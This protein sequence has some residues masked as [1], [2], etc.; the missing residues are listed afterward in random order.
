MDRRFAPVRMLGAQMR[1]R[2]TQVAMA[3]LTFYSLPSAMLHAGTCE[4]PSSRMI[5]SGEGSSLAVSGGLLAA[6]F[7]DSIVLFDVSDSEHAK[8]LGDLE[9]VT[10][11]PDFAVSM[12]LEAP[13]LAAITNLGL[14][15]IDISCPASPKIEGFIDD[16][17]PEN[18]FPE[19]VILRNALAFVFAWSANGL[20]KEGI[21][22]YDV[23]QPAMPSRI[24]FV[25]LDGVRA[26]AASGRF[27][28]A[29]R[30]DKLFVIDATNAAHPEVV[31]E[32]AFASQDNSSKIVHDTKWLYVGASDITATPIVRIYSLASL[33]DLDSV[34]EISIPEA[35]SVVVLDKVHDFLFLSSPE[36]GVVAYDVADPQHAFPVGHSLQGTWPT[37]YD[38]VDSEQGIFFVNTLGLWQMSFNICPGAE[39]FLPIVAHTT[40]VGGAKY[41]TDL[42]LINTSSHT[43][44][45]VLEFWP[46]GAS[47]EGHLRTP[48]L[49]AA[50]EAREVTDAIPTLF[51]TNDA[52]GTLFASSSPNIQ[53]GARIYEADSATAI[54]VEPQT[55]T[56][57]TGRPSS[58]SPLLVSDRVRFNL[59][60]ANKSSVARVVH[61]QVV[62]FSADSQFERDLVIPPRSA[63]Q[64]NDTVPARSNSESFI[65]SVRLIPDGPGTIAYLTENSTTSRQFTL[66]LPNP[67]QE[68]EPPSSCESTNLIR[69]APVRVRRNVRKPTRR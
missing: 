5:E 25:A 32:I 21:Y 59:G 43:E 19:K 44:A 15:M 29:A 20:D 40:G 26:I 23:S 8:Q 39:R 13:L 12:S 30:G 66:L 31:H 22:V 67:L 46:R 24:G 48:L 16:L 45:L 6:G 65:A 35:T 10:Q 9:L 2:L 14:T 56:L 50:G 17:R 51:Q 11:P 38:L 63:L 49:L 33:P 42:F 7:R 53:L 64:W 34:A 41:R 60:L 4:L 54:R 62:D 1:V 57:P 68:S 27:L 47:E 58:F 61:L 55:A 36:T 52:A 37:G 28:L 69:Q 3:L 18:T